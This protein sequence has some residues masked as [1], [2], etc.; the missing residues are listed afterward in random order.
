[1]PQPSLGPS[2]APNASAMAPGECAARR[3]VTRTPVETVFDRAAELSA[4]EYDRQRDQ[5]AKDL[6][7]RKSTLDDEVGKRRRGR[8]EEKKLFLVE[9]PPWETPVDGA[10]LLDAIVAELVKYLVLPKHSPE[11]IALWIVHAHALDAFQ[12]SPILALLSPEKRCGKTTT[13]TVAS[14]FFR[15][16]CSPAIRVQHRYSA[17]SR[18]STRRCSSMNSIHIIEITKKSAASSTPDTCAVG[19]SSCVVS[20]MTSNRRPSRRG[21]RRSSR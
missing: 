4:I 6:G 14:I 11:A 5:M 12:C 16:P 1:M 20:V 15:A 13:L 2:A 19:R 17:Q 7:I 9:P 18:R 8:E 10:D 3:T 21:G